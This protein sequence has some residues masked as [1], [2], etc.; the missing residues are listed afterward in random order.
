MIIYYISFA[1]Q[2]KLLYDMA[3]NSHHS[4]T[5]K[6]SFMSEFYVF[7]S[8]QQRGNK[9][10]GKREKGRGRMTMTKYSEVSQT[11]MLKSHYTV[12]VLTTTGQWDCSRPEKV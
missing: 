3:P 7:I 4:K 1:F 5:Y 12:W 11:G 10:W 8:G 9:K 2:L 6:T